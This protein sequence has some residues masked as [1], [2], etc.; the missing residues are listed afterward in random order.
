M[1][2]L[3]LALLVALAVANVGSCSSG[4]RV[5]TSLGFKSAAIWLWTAS[6]NYTSYFHVSSVCSSGNMFSS[7]RVS[8]VLMAGF[9]WWSAIGFGTLDLS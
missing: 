8:F 4:Y 7:P 5:C 1:L 2:S 6:T 9:H 3:L